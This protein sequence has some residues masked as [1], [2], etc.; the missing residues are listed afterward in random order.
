MLILIELYSLIGFH[1]F[2]LLSIAGLLMS[3]I[4]F[5]LVFLVHR[6]LEL[7]SCVGNI[8]CI[9]LI[10]RYI[11][12][13][14]TIKICQRSGCLYTGLPGAYEYLVF[15]AAS[16]H[17][18]THR[19]VLGIILVWINDTGHMSRNDPGPYKLFGDFS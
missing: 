7:G 12:G 8:T 1:D 11:S 18:Y 2:T 13:K 16:G 19:I 5:V 6:L 9:V 15:P 14:D 17:L 10:C 3:A 4:L